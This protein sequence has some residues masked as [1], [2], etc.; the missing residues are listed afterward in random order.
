MP[1]NIT[2][3][4]GSKPIQLKPLNRIMI[5]DRRR[6]EI[7]EIKVRTMGFLRCFSIKSLSTILSA[8]HKT[9]D[10]RAKI[11]QFILQSYQF[12]GCLR[13]KN[14]CINSGNFVYRFFEWR[15]R[16]TESD[17]LL[18]PPVAPFELIKSSLK[19]LCFFLN[20]L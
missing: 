7:P 13:R 15:N 9:L 1:A 20:S 14:Y 10:K 3:S 18:S 8:A 19:F 12:S 16:T 2:K 5:I 11:T 6:A 4:V 17:F